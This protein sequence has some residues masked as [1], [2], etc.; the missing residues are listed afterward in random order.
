[1][2]GV[3][4]LGSKVKDLQ[5]GAR[6]SESG[7]WAN[8][9]AHVTY[10]VPGDPDLRL[11]RPFD[12][13]DFRGSYS[14]TGQVEPTANLLMRGVLLGDTIESGERPMGLW[15][16]FTSYDVIC[17]PGAC[18]MAAQMS[19]AFGISVSSSF[20]KLVP[21][22]VVDVSTIGD[23]PVTVTVSWRVATC[24]CWSTVSV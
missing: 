20:V 21:I 5:T 1:M 23:S 15:G 10:G 11:R 2:K 9:G 18:D 7:P 16:L 19:R 8:V 4:V 22:V 13:F 3:A 6:E 12:H 14:F 17:I 24:S